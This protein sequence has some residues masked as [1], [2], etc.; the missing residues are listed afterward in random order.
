MLVPSKPYDRGNDV[1]KTEAIKLI[2]K[3]EGSATLRLF[4]ILLLFLSLFLSLGWLLG[5]GSDSGNNAIYSVLLAI[6]VIFVCDFA[7]LCIMKADYVLSF[8]FWTDLMGT[9]AILL[10]IGWI[11]GNAVGSDAVVISSVI[12]SSRATQLVVFGA[13]LGRTLRAMKFLNMTYDMTRVDE[14]ILGNHAT[15]D[16]IRRMKSNLSMEVSYRAAA[17]ALIFAIVVPFMTYK[18]DDS[19]VQAWIDSM[20]TVAKINS[21]STE[22]ELEAVVRSFHGFYM[23]R[24]LKPLNVYIQTPWGTPVDKSFHHRTVLRDENVIDYDDHYWAYPVTASGQRN[25]S[26]LVRYGVWV[27][28]DGTVI[29]QWEAFFG[30]MLIV[31]VIIVLVVFTHS[32]Q[33]TVKRLVMVPYERISLSLR[34]NAESM[35]RSLQSLR[36]EYGGTSTQLCPSE[37]VK[38]DADLVVVMD[39]VATKGKG[40]GRGRLSKY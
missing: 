13:Q 28:M 12:R 39:K 19:G 9:L 15:N 31:L 5:N 16:A 24:D 1:D 2:E 17:L 30:I 26:A 29:A 32:F 27:A 8:F 21:S 6:F 11:T 7:F 3:Y 37:E 4:H 35:I 34:K 18:D 22:S 25:G 33:H 38:L 40:S 10:D 20:K 14:A 36:E 23:D